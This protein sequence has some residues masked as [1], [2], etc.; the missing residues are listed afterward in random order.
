MSPAR[1]S[2]PGSLEIFDTGPFLLSYCALAWAYDDRGR[3]LAHRRRARQR[4]RRQDS[5]RARG[6]WLRSHHRRGAFLPY[7]RPPLTKGFLLGKQT[8][9][10]LPVLKDGYFRDR[11]VQVLLDTRAL[12]IE[13]EHRC[14]RTDRAGDFKYRKLLIATGC[15]PHRIEAPGAELPGVFYLRTL[16]D[17]EDL[18]QAMAGAKRAAVIGSSFIAMELAA[19]FAEQGIETTLT[20]REDRLYSRLDSPEVSTFFADYYRA[21]GV[22]ILFNETVKAFTGR[23]RVQR[24]ITSS[25]KKIAC[26]LVAVASIPIS[27]LSQAAVSSSNTEFWS[28][29]TWRQATPASTPRATS[30]ASSTPYS[31]VIG[32]SSIGTT[33]PSRAVSPRSTFLPILYPNEW[34]IHWT[35]FYDPTPVKA[36]LERYIDFKR[37]K[38][39]PVRLMVGAV[40]VETAELETFDSYNQEITPDHILASGSLPPGVP[41]TTIGDKHYWDRGIVSNTPLDQI[42]ERLGCAGKKVYIVNLY[43]RKKA[44][45]RSLAEVMDR[46]DEICYSEKIR[47]DIHFRQLLDRY[48]QLVEEIMGRVDQQLVDEIKHN[49]LYLQ[50][51]GDAPPLAITRIVHEG[52]EGGPPSKD[53]DFSRATIA[54]HQRAGYRVAVEA[55]D[56]E[57]SERV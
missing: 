25:G 38:E 6:Q 48:R 57:A 55:L 29:S 40:N 17:A 23:G 20:A 44:L 45:P 46:R 14:V 30:P 26:D 47:R 49:P 35:S 50:T 42:I 13:P 32:A 41:W 11:D 5:E 28:T 34:P 19:S 54:A 4:N 15:R 10:S 3:F 27:G 36:L 2:R 33:P 24:L 37:L 53:N 16:A 12:S 43:P 1:F 8:R 56:Q 7:H 39:S 22:A 21:R 31:A 51:M 52:E 18:K 9:E